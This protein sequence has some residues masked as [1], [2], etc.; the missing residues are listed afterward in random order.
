[1]GRLFATSEVPVETLDVLSSCTVVTG[2]REVRPEGPCSGLTPCKES[3][4]LG[5]AM[6]SCAIQF[7]LV[8]GGLRVFSC[9]TTKLSIGILRY[10]E[11]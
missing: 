8:L 4:I 7:L 10:L 9:F 1:M 3:Q 5:F 11:F 2:S 6:E